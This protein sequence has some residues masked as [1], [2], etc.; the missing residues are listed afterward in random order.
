MAK[1]AAA[2]V[3]LRDQINKRFPKRDKRSDGWIGD[4][5]HQA[6]PSDHNPDSH[7]IVH[8]L[9]VDEDLGASGASRKL[10][11]QLIELARNGQDRG[12][13]KYVVYEDKIASGTY[14]DS[15]WTW[16][17][18]GYG[19]TEHIHVSFTPKAEKD[20]AAFPLPVLV[21]GIWDGIVPALEV[22]QAAERNGRPSPG[23]WRL[24]CRLA[25]LGYYQGTPL[26]R[27]EQGYPSKAVA[28]AQAAA[29]L[30]A[31]GNYTPRTH[32]AIFA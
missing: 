19:H 9:D 12:R 13:L 20:G 4:S 30:P 21:G 31:V 17:G 27:G 29:G 28:A 10:A 22:I 7:G 3:T 24:A 8:A 14:R 6:R 15:F 5:A 18:S 32:R 2:G 11:D 16:R 26:P 23:V 25:D 1:L